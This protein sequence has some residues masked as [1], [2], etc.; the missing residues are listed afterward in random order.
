MAFWMLKTM[1]K[2]NKQIL[3]QSLKR[4][5]MKLILT[6]CSSLFMMAGLA[7]TGASTS[8]LLLTLE[9]AATAIIAWF[10]FHENF[11]RRI[12][13]GMAFLVTG[14]AT[15]GWAGTPSLDS[16]AAPLLSP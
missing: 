1:H 16:V 7:R 9:G 2:P 8:S 11:D 13:L 4:L 5:N 12:A 15:L 3:I 10:I 14:A 6:I